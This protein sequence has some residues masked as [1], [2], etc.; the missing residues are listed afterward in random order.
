MITNNRNNISI[1]Y[2]IG[3]FLKFLI[4]LP[5][6]FHQLLKAWY[7]TKL[8]EALPQMDKL[9]FPMWAPFPLTPN[10]YFHLAHV[11]AKLFETWRLSP[12]LVSET[13]GL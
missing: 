10:V 12:V 9:Q 2:P 8:P 4:W 7:L 5:T 3:C 6:F 1:E 11:Y 13:N